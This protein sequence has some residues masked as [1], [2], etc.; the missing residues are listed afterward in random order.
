MLLPL[1]AYW[2]KI[3]QQYHNQG[4]LVWPRKSDLG[5]METLKDPIVILMQTAQVNEPH[6]G[7]TADKCIVSDTKC[8]TINNFC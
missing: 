7:S 3:K 5:K 8:P 1:N 4:Y 6:I 2:E